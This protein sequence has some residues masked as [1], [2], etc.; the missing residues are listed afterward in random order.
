MFRRL[1][2]AAATI[3]AAAGLVAVSGGALQPS[4]ATVPNPTSCQNQAMNVTIPVTSPVVVQ[5]GLSPGG[6]GF[7]AAVVCIG[8]NG[9]P[10]GG[11]T[12]QEFLVQG[13]PAGPGAPLSCNGT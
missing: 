12:Y 11:I 9:G 3:V 7:S 4:A 5:V 2:T 10:T 8:T 1:R 13:Q 6:T